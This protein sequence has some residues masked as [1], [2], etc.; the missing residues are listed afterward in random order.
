MTIRHRPLCEVRFS[1]GFEFDDHAVANRAA[2]N[3]AV[4]NHDLRRDGPAPTEDVPAAAVAE[5]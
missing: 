3:H 1:T 5:R 4:T 2:T